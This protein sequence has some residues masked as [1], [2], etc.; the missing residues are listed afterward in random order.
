MAKIKGISKIQSAIRGYLS[1]AYY[2]T[3]CTSVLIAAVS[4]QSSWRRHYIQRHYKMFRTT[5]IKYIAIARSVSLAF[6]LRRRYLKYDEAVRC[7]QRAWKCSPL[8][9]SL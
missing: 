7:I 5:R 2:A 9:Q 3:Y 6:S 4:I 1:R 8:A